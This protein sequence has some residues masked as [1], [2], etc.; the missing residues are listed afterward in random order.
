MKNSEI[1]KFLS[2]KEFSAEM[3]AH[4]V[5]QWLGTT[6]NTKFAAAKKVFME[7]SEEA[8]YFQT[9]DAAIAAARATP[10][11]DYEFENS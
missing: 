7:A 2:E 11:A 1:E 8:S 4:E 5:C 9:Q 10:V 3:Q 6:S